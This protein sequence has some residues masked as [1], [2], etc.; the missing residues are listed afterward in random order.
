MATSHVETGED[1]IGEPSFRRRRQCSSQCVRSRLSPKQT[2]YYPTVSVLYV[3]VVHLNWLATWTGITRY[4]SLRTALGEPEKATGFCRWSVRFLLS[5]S[6]FA[7][8]RLSLNTSFTAVSVWAART[9]RLTPF[10]TSIERQEDTPHEQYTSK[11]L[12]YSCLIG[13]SNSA[14]THTWSLF[15]KCHEF[16]SMSVHSTWSCDSTYDN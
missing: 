11:H 6:M 16:H 8:L 5:L 9:P 3:S 7:S 2:S 1:R 14:P 12:I 15:W 10:A 4:K 13:P